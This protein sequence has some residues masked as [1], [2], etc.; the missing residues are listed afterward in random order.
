MAAAPQ[1]AF[2][3]TYDPDSVRAA[4]HSLFLMQ[5]RRTLW[6]TVGSLAFCFLTI[7]G[8]SLYLQ[9]F[10][11]LWVP[12]GF[13]ALD[14]VLRLYVRWAIRRRLERTLMGKSAQIEL[15]DAT[16]SIASESGSH[17]LPWR[18]FTS[19]RRDPSN[20]LLCFPRPGAIVLPAKTA[21]NGAFEFAEARVRDAN[22]A[23]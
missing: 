14:V 19:T 18:S 4:A 7:G 17:V 2:A 9:F 15:S 23:V 16:F 21:P 13:L 5:Q 1:F 10:W 12:G 11:M 22:A 3:I 20:L 6:L 8:I